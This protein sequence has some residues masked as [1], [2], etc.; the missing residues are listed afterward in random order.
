[1]CS[2]LSVW[3][4]LADKIARY[5]YQLRMLTQLY[6]E[7][8][9][10]FE[11]LLVIRLHFRPGRFTLLQLIGRLL[12]GNWVPACW[13]RLRGP[14]GELQDLGPHA[15]YSLEQW[16]ILAALWVPSLFLAFQVINDIGDDQFPMEREFLAGKEHIEQEHHHPNAGNPLSGFPAHDGSFGDR[17]LCGQLGLRPTPGKARPLE[18][19]GKARWPVYL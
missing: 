7:R 8:K 13:S 1:M 6:H 16:I 14:H 15:L 5:R 4:Q 10:G 18:R 12:L 3:C 11:R 17:E 2:V 19:S 9:Q